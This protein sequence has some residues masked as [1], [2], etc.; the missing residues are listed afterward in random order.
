MYSELCCER[1]ATDQ[2][3]QHVK[4]IKTDHEQR[5]NGKPLVH[6][7]RDE[8]NER[9]HGEDGDEHAII[10]DGCVAGNGIMDHI[11]DQGQD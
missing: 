1:N 10:D 5:V 11:P 3:E 7:G 6:R 4:A 8:I 9:E 2:K